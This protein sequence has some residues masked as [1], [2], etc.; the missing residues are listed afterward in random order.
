MHRQCTLLYRLLLYASSRSSSTNSNYLGV[1][2][3]VRV[4]Q[5]GPVCKC[6]HVTVS[7]SLPSTRFAEYVKLT[8]AW[9]VAMEQRTCITRHGRRRRRR[10]HSLAVCGYPALGLV[11][12]LNFAQDLDAA[13]CCRVRR[14]A[15]KVRG[16]CCCERE[17]APSVG[18]V[19]ARLLFTQRR[20]AHFGAKCR[21]GGR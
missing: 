18:K 15:S 21:S 20:P 7:I 17:R 3:V 8:R 12:H 1:F 19:V 4:P 16:R 10:Q 6:R 2:R 13:H 5:R 14:L 11:A 9:D